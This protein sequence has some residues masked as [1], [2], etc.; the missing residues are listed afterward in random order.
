MK[1]NVMLKLFWQGLLNTDTEHLP[2]RL[3]L[4]QVLSVR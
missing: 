1:I 4:L 3:N 2:L